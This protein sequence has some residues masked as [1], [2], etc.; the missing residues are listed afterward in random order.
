MEKKSFVE[1]VMAKLQGGDQAKLER[2]KEKLDKYFKTQIRMKR[3]A[4][5]RIEDTISDQLGDVQDTILNVDTSHLNKG[6]DADN[7]CPTYV[8]AVDKARKEVEKS[9]LQIEAIEEEIK[10][11]EANRDLIFNTEETTVAPQA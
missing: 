3:E 5:E 10:D 9:K 1:R 6:S 2:F 7:Y 4:I 11:L 8:A